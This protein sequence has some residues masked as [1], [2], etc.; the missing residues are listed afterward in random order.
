MKNRKLI[1]LLLAMFILLFS[2]S[3]ALA[4]APAD[5]PAPASTQA[6]GK[7]KP[8]KLK[9][10]PQ[11]FSG[12]VVSRTS[13]QL[14]LALSNGTQIPFVIDSNTRVKIP[15]MNGA[16]LN[17]LTIGMQI[18]VMARPDLSGA[19]VAQKVMAVPGKPARSH[20]VG[21]VT[22]YTPGK[23]IT[24]KDKDGNLTTFTL[25]PGA[26]LL[27]PKR[28]AQLAVGSRVTVISRNNPSG[29][30]YT[31]QGVVVHPAK[32]QDDGEDD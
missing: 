28:A 30:G 8:D 11:K 15:T 4:S 13:N 23:S 21:T 7:G 26:K 25:E 18:R 1:V 32:G 29:T 9:G 20:R 3:Q 16:G 5:K 19:L 31:A 17:D 10:K 6:A 24:V 22:A 27:P 14:I 12:T 2:A